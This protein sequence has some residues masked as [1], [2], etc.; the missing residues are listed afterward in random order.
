MNLEETFKSLIADYSADSAFAN[1]LWL[2]IV[3]QYSGKGRAYHNLV[4][5]EELMTELLACKTETADWNALLFTLFYHDIIYKAR[6][7]DNETQSALLA[8][9]RM[10]QCG[11]SLSLQ[12]KVSDYILATQSHSLH[13]DHDCNLFT[14]ADLS[15]LGK[16]WDRYAAYTSQVRKEY[17]IYPYFLY[18]TGRKKVVRHFLN[19]DPL[20]KT[21]HFRRNYALQA[22]QNLELELQ[23]L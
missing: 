20:Y 3:G 21:T 23:K 22:R 5:L 7:R 12:E 4:H 13:S 2:E 11:C 8:K 16:P 19:M 6:R 1:T 14:D 9:K 17:R 10:E 18:K 15:I